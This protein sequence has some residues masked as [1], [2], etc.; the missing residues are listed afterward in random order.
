MESKSFKDLV[1]W[2]KGHSFILCVYKYTK[3]FPNFELFGLISQFRRAT[4]SLTIIPHSF[5]N[6]F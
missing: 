3:K 1:M 2:R 6:F 5:Y 4:I